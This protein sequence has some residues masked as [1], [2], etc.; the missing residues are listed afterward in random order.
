MVNVGCATMQTMM[1]DIINSY[2]SAC[3]LFATWHGIFSHGLV[4]NPSDLRKSIEDASID[5]QNGNAK[6]LNMINNMAIDPSVATVA[7]LRA[8]F[9][10]A[11]YAVITRVFFATF[12]FYDV[13]EAVAKYTAK[14]CKKLHIA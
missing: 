5:L 1:L 14:N 6:L 3:S 10:N 8:E 9:D 7:V 12:A 4:T 11:V 2:L 13:K